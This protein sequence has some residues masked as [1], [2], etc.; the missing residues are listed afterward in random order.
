MYGFTISGTA[1]NNLG[2][3]YIY[4]SITDGTFDAYGYTL[5]LTWKKV[6]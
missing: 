5:T 6:V 2:G 3:Q 4:V 1:I